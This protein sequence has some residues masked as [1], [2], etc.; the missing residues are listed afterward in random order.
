MFFF[1]LVITL[2][3]YYLHYLLG[4]YWH[5][6]LEHLV[7]GT[8]GWRFESTH[9]DHENKEPHIVLSTGEFFILPK[10]IPEDSLLRM[11]L[12]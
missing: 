11:I 5:Y 3:F 7:P 10:G 9:S 6:V 12:R 2:K 4:S 1:I 8:R